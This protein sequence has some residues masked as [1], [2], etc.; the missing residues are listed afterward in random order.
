MSKY[1]RLFVENAVFTT[2]KE[3]LAKALFVKS[4]TSKI[5][6]AVGSIRTIPA[7]EVEE[8]GTGRRYSCDIRDI[9][10]RLY[11]ADGLFE[12][13]CM[14]DSYGDEPTERMAIAAGV[15][16]HHYRA[17]YGHTVASFSGTAVV[18]MAD[19]RKYK[20]VGRSA[21]G[22]PHEA[23]NGYVEFTRI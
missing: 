21:T 5:F 1:S 10:K 22:T 4:A 11:G 18:T 2:A 17:G 3:D 9:A 19:G 7:V 16:T 12:V 15:E 8:W 13:E 14:A 23:F 20:A 6:K